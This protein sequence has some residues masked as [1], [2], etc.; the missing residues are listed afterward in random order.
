MKNKLLEELFIALILTLVIILF[1]YFLIPDT[2][3]EVQ[4]SL[5]QVIPQAEMKS[6]MAYHG[7]NF[8]ARNVDGVW[9]F[10]RDGQIVKLK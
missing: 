8:V 5:G 10:E 3:I 6:L 7:V 2:E 1:L 4:G 9:V